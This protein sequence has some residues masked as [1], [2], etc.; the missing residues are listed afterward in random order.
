MEHGNSAWSY[1]KDK[2]I[3]GAL[4]GG[5]STPFTVPLGIEFYRIFTGAPA[6]MVHTRRTVEIETLSGW[7]F[8]QKRTYYL[9]NKIYQI[10]DDSGDFVLDKN[11]R[12]TIA[13]NRDWYSH[14]IE[15]EVSSVGIRRELEEYV[16]GL[17]SEG[18]E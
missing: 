14:W 16:D 1:W 10:A 9:K 11:E 4:L 13:E 17:A 15:Q 18:G 8:D 5:M 2:I 6:R 7:I 12:R 3:V